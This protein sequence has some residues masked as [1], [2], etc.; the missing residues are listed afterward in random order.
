MAHIHIV[1]AGLAGLAAALRLADGTRQITI[2][3]SAPQ[4]GGRCR[5]Y[6]DTT[7]GLEIDNGNH[8]LLSG[9]Y[10]AQEFL[11]TVGSEGELVGPPHAEF[12]FVDLKTRERWQLKPSH[13]AIPWW[14]FQ[15][16]RRVPGTG[17]LDYFSVLPLM[18][19]GKGAALKDA[20]TC[21]GTLWQRLWHPFFLAALNTEPEDGAA[22]L[23]ARLLQETLAKGG[24]ACRPLVAH[25]LSRAFIDP[26]LR[27]LEAKGVEIRFERR[28]SGLAAVGTAVKNLQFGAEAMTLNPDDRVV[29]AVPAPVAASLLPALP[30]P[31]SFRAIVNAHYKIAP[32][33]RQPPI[34]GVINGTME[35]LFAFPDRLSVT[36]SGADRLIS[37][38][39]EDLAAQIWSEIQLVTEVASPLPAWQIIKEKRATFAATPAE[40]ARRP[41]TRGAWTNLLLAGDW[42]NTGLPATI[43]G[44]IRSGFAA[45]DAI[46]AE[47]SL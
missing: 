19:A 47:A 7:L 27:H 28:L 36:I 26:A 2:H 46:L 22:T 5:S 32:P 15:K 35:W 17:P 12:D 25:G 40:E 9:N 3:E 11:R 44:A 16:S 10:A 13:G 23:A 6:F 45:A 42:T 34:L 4:A 30:T 14:I 37:A 1:G 41:N 21:Q 20:M 39:R 18:R 33:P 38:P 31:Q 24:R 43:E 29:L 8:L